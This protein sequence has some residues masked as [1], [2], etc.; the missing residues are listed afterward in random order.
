MAWFFKFLD[1]SIGQKILMSLTGLFLIL[2]LAVHLAGNLQLLKSDCGE[3]FNTYAYFMTHNPLIK[4]IS[5][6]NYAFIL[7]HAFQGIRIWRAN[8][9]ARGPIKYAVN[10]TR[11]SERSA[12]N[13]AWLGIILLVFI[14]LHMYQFWFQMH[15]GTLPAVEVAAYDHPVNNLYIPAVAAYGNIFYVLFYVICMGVVGMHLWHG[16]WSA[17]QTLG[18]NHRKYNPVI[19]VIGYAYATIVP[20]GFAIIP[21]YMYFMN[22]DIKAACNILTQL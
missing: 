21:L 14:I 17:F 4:V 11:S 6:G 3:S 22:K 12:R 1:S 2:F 10:H 5:Y 15:F 16:F 8:I 20:V 9:A 7:L 13:M 19:R 18:L